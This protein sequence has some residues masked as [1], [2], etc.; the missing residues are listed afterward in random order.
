[1]AAI[2]QYPH[3]LFVVET[4]ETYRDEDGNWVPGET[5]HVFKSKCRDEKNGKALKI[6]LAGGEFYLFSSL[7]QLPKGTDGYGKGTEV[8]VTN[9]MAGN[10]VRIKAQVSDCDKGQLHSRLWL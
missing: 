4:T 2:E 8:V 10:D 9:D 6:Q 5:K 3:F 7:I 1:M